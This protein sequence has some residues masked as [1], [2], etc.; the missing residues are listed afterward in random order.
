MA[1]EVVMAEDEER[2]RIRAALRA[3]PWPTVSVDPAQESVQDDFEFDVHAGP[4]EQ[5]GETAGFREGPGSGIEFGPVVPNET[6]VV[7]EIQDAVRRR[8]NDYM[9]QGFAFDEAR[10]SAIGDVYEITNR[11]ITP[12]RKKIKSEDIAKD[13]A[14]LEGFQ[15][16]RESLKRQKLGFQEEAPEGQTLAE[17]A[18]TTRLTGGEVVESRLHQSLRVLGGISRVAIEPLMQFSTYE[19]DEEGNPVDPNDIAYRIEQSLP[20][21]IR[22]TYTFGWWPR[23]FQGA[24]RTDPSSPYQAIESGDLF[25]DIAHSIASGRSLVD[26]FKSME[27][28]RKFWVDSARELDMPILQYVPT[29]A[30]FGTELPMNILPGSGVATGAAKGTVRVAA[31]AARKAGMSR[32]ARVLDTI[33]SP[34]RQARK[35]RAVHEAERIQEGLPQRIESFDDVV[36]HYGVQDVMARHIADEVTRPAML[37]REL[38]ALEEGVEH[39]PTRM[40]DDFLESATVREIAERSMDE[41]G[42]MSRAKMLDELATWE[43]ALDEQATLKMLSPE[44]GTALNIGR[45]TLEEAGTLANRV[46]QN[47]AA[48][49][50]TGL[51]GQTAIREARVLTAKQQTMARIAD[52][53]PNDYVLLTPTSIISMKAAKQIAPELGRNVDALMR[54][55]RV[56][57]EAG[58]GGHVFDDADAVIRAL[59]E[60]VG[61]D[62]ME[63]SSIWREVTEAMLKSEGIPH[64]AALNIRAHVTEG[65]ARQLVDKAPGLKVSEF[66]RGLEG[67]LAME[68]AAR[69]I[70]RRVQTLE[71]A[72]ELV[73]DVVPEKLGRAIASAEVLPRAVQNYVRKNMPKFVRPDASR[74]PTPTLQWLGSTEGLLQQ[75]VQNFMREASEVINKAPT[76]E[77]GYQ[78][79]INQTIKE[80]STLHKKGGDATR[81]WNAWRGVVDKFF[82][83]EAGMIHDFQLRRYIGYPP[84]DLT[85]KD[86]AKV[87]QA[88]RKDSDAL[89]GAGLKTSAVAGVDN[90]AGAFTAWMVEQRAMRVVARSY[91]EFLE[92]NPH[93]AL[94][95]Q[96][97]LKTPSVVARDE[98]TEIIKTTIDIVENPKA[99]DLLVNLSENLIR[100]T[101]R[102]MSDENR[103]D[104]IS[105]MIQHKVA[106]GNPTAKLSALEALPKATGQLISKDRLSLEIAALMEEAGTPVLK[107]AADKMASGLQELM[108]NVVTRNMDSLATQHLQSLGMM[109]GSNPASYRNIATRLFRLPGRDKVAALYGDD[110]AEMVNRLKS[111][112][113]NGTLERNLE[114]L[115]GTTEGDWVFRSLGAFLDGMRRW[116]IGGLLGGF[117]LPNTRFLGLNALTAPL[118]VATS[119]G[120]KHAFRALGLNKTNRMLNWAAVKNGAKAD[121]VIFETN[122][123]QWTRADLE[124]AIQRNNVKY[125]QI[126]FEFSDV[127]INDIMRALK[128]DRKMRTAG[129]VRQI[130]RQ[131]DPGNK[132]LWSRFAEQTDNYFRQNVFISAIK[133]GRTEAEAAKLAQNALLDYGSLGRAERDVIARGMYFY[134]FRRL[135]AENV[136]RTAIERPKLLVQMARTQKEQAKESGIWMTAPDHAL[137]R[138]WSSMGETYDKN[139]QSGVFGP[140]NPAITA[141]LDIF[142]IGMLPFNAISG[143]PELISETVKDIPEIAYN[144]IIDGIFK[145]IAASK[146]KGHAGFVPPEHIVFFK[147]MGMWEPFEKSFG[148]VSVPSERE[149]RRGQPTQKGLQYR[150]MD[151]DGYSKYII[152]MHAL[153]ASAIKRNIQDYAKIGIAAGIYPEGFEPKRLDDGNWYMIAGNLQT[154]MNIPDNVMQYDSMLKTMRRDLQNLSTP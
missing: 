92:L 42:N 50:R 74:T 148:V 63:A 81:T 142:N 47:G 56:V 61:A 8:Q 100:R 113:S 77:Q 76:H 101:S 110:A 22:E 16:L 120:P 115:Y 89:R 145:L 82:G 138:L 46:S 57:D 15:A 73:Q 59:E 122:G 34:V 94:K 118:I 117:P 106:I 83:P 149:M 133:E 33:H 55:T 24:T 26:D 52:R 98:L 49:R 146:E 104:I 97:Y 109:A 25:K 147:Q 38:D 9:G 130:L 12:G 39:V 68:R 21:D 105:L 70:E 1:D 62:V 10:Q 127:V 27:N 6:D 102:V 107:Q 112:V 153:T 125:S 11:G 35:R 141:L 139:V 86:F 31:D 72:A 40:M 13:L 93:L 116:S 71:R 20:E 28:Y 126:G 152:F 99:T 36:D 18:L 58:V 111:A 4:Q 80:S 128:I 84:K 87:V 44:V 119:I 75:N 90:Y 154:P 85:P 5:T 64:K 132:N 45:N 37:R 108:V 19:V 123:V 151:K 143:D 114:K 48:L 103:T 134:A 150:F 88:I 2:E 3:V 51:R 140:D 137:T 78:N 144:P 96:N 17:R 95:A 7:K 29:A 43:K 41:A 79:L 53:V 14:D 124:E 54:G 136:V 60:T 121:E 91:D 135:M 65:V 67:G 30:G 129:N 23:P 69:P 32:G 66:Q 131:I